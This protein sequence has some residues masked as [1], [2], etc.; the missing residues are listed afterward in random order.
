MHNSD[1]LMIARV[2]AY[3]HMYIKL[4]RTNNVLQNVCYILDRTKGVYP[5]IILFGSIVFDWTC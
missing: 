3:N 5:V 4:N 2:V 1:E